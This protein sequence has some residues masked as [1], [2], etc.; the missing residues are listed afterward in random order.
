MLAYTRNIFITSL[1]ALFLLTACD[2]DKPQL[3]NGGD[4]ASIQVS[5]PIST[6]ETDEAELNSQ[7]VA[8]ECLDI[9]EANSTQ[10][11]STVKLGAQAGFSCSLD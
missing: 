3:Q 7:N 1:T 4:S 5:V 6:S 9:N 8:D 11:D 2:N 10:T